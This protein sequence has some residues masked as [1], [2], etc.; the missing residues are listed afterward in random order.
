MT[1][2]NPED[3]LQGFS[4]RL[5]DAVERAG[6]S[7]VQIVGNGR[8]ATGVIVGADRVLTVD[9]LL[10]RQD[11]LRVRTPDGRTL[12][13][14]F[15]GRDPST[16]LALVRVA[17]LGGTPM[18]P[19]SGLPRAGDIAL[20]VARASGGAVVAS[21]GLVAGVAGPLRGGRG[22]AL[23]QVIRVDAFSS[24]GFTGG[25]LVDARGE[26][27]GITN[28]ALVRGMRLAIPADRAWKA[29]ETIATHGS[30]K[31]GYLGIGS[32]PVAIPEPQRGG[33]ADE[34]GL[35]VLGVARESPADRAGVFVGDII[36]EFDRRATTDPAE[37][38]ARLGPDRVGTTPPLTV[39]RAGAVHELRVTVGS[40]D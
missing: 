22:P 16:D 29:A 38:L 26:A 8:P 7:L 39:L 30:I 19:A 5:A 28:A 13:A 23:D 18:H 15:A 31:R 12:A 14:S 33:R 2:L 32:Q 36:V 37:L 4:A 1:T 11:D 25:A 21:F 20:A 6:A 35:L 3:L 27:I 34:R 17:D 10:H 40:R 24:P 9:H